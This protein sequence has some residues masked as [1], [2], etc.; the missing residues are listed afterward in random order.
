MYGFNVLHVTSVLAMA[1]ADV[2]RASS[3]SAQRLRRSRELC[4]GTRPVTSS[5]A[6]TASG[7]IPG[8]SL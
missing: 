2:D 3:A 8:S 7:V 5:P 6:A 4:S 1:A